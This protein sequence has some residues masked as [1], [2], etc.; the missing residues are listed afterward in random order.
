M[1]RHIARYGRGSLR[2]V[3]LDENREHL[4]ERGSVLAARYDAATG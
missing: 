2:L 3:A 1:L 4:V